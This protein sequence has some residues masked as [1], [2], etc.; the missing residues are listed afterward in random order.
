M[1]WGNPGGWGVGV[2]L[3]VAGAAVALLKN[4]IEG[5]LKAAYNWVI[6]RMAGSVLLRRTVLRRYARAVREAYGTVPLPFTMSG[7]LSMSDIYVPLAAQVRREAGGGVVVSGGGRDAY[8]VL[9]G[10]PRAVVVGDPGAGKS[11]LFRHAVLRW[12]T[13]AAP[14][15]DVAVVVSL[16]R[17]V[18]AD[19]R[20]DI[21]TLVAEEFARRRFPKADKFIERALVSGAL[22]VYLDGLDEVPSDS[23]AWAMRHV[24][25][26]AAPYPKARIFVSC[27]T[28]VYDGGLR[29]GFREVLRIGEFDDR[30][31]R[32]FLTAWPGLPEGRETVDQLTSALRDAPR[33]MQL[34]RN[35]LLLTMIAYLYSEVYVHSGRRLPHSRAEFYREVTTELLSRWN[36]RQNRYEGP[37]KKLVLQRL[38]LAAMDGGGP[39]HDRLALPYHDVVRRIGEMLPD[40][41]REPA[42]AR[43]ILE[44]IVQRSGFLV[45]VD[46]GD[47]VQ[48]AHLTLQEFFAAQQLQGDGDGLLDRFRGDPD[49][50]RETVRLW[51]GVAEQDCSAF[52]DAL[53][54]IDEV[55]A[56]TCLA[57]AHGVAEP[58]AERIQARADALMEGASTPEIASAYANMAAA[59][60][61]RGRA[62]GQFLRDL[63]HRHH[64]GAYT[65]LSLTNSPWAAEVLAQRVADDADEVAAAL[66]RMGDVAIPALARM[67]QCR[68]RT[69]A[70]ELIGTPTA[71]LT[72]LAWARDSSANVVRNAL[73][74]ASVFRN[75]GVADE[76]GRMPRTYG[77][78]VSDIVWR[79][80]AQGSGASVASMLAETVVDV[81]QSWVDD[82]EQIDLPV[83]RIDRRLGFAVLLLEVNASLAVDE[84]GRTWH[85]P[86][87]SWAAETGALRMEL[88][89][90]R[91]SA[92]TC[93]RDA[94]WRHVERFLRRIG[95]S[96][97]RLLVL[98]AM[99]PED[100]DAAAD[101]LLAGGYITRDLWAELGNPTS[102]PPGR[103][104]LF[105][106]WRRAENQDEYEIFLR[107]REL[108]AVELGFRGAG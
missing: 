92:E 12:A 30:M 97:L 18:D 21:R 20:R 57:E 65:A 76:L 16:A 37:D 10:V 103:R 75:P 19:E 91:G 48:F 84:D 69:R 61:P 74:A 107:L 9:R 32:R 80:F 108:L 71:A 89:G 86:V 53:L 4:T 59:Q 72:L 100:R 26:F 50:W 79:P 13:G 47:K 78:S 88:R 52:L 31:M 24:E 70:L 51:C 14:G 46:G 27:R 2:G 95:F 41:N 90:S 17:L 15:R 49:R 39:A 5:A 85:V 35:P 25:D 105:G 64:P 55:L 6:D 102:A 45:Y 98:N 67:P 3:F 8:E 83:G 66:A 82:G 62:T 1:D 38:A 11:M 87:S 101:L 54:A 73:A 94:A 23:R 77:S 40:L 104:T 7:A 60:T 44:E 29:D 42:E 34:A 81:L 28:A 36:N 93:G 58:T 106:R 56:F 99:A 96:P 63:A 68:G 33:V 22:T 43:D